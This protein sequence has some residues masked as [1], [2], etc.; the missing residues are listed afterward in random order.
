VSIL[1]HCNTFAGQKKE[2]ISLVFTSNSFQLVSASFHTVSVLVQLAFLPQ[3][4]H[5]KSVGFLVELFIGKFKK[6]DY[7]HLAVMN[8]LLASASHSYQ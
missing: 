7:S 1:A 8:D 4:A 6:L 2:V 5:I 3:L